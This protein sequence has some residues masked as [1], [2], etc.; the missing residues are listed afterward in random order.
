MVNLDSKSIAVIVLFIVIFCGALFDIPN[1]MLVGLC[2][3]ASGGALCVSDMFNKPKNE[4]KERERRSQETRKYSYEQNYVRTLINISNIK[5][6]DKFAATDWVWS[7]GHYYP[8]KDPAHDSYSQMIL[9]LKNKE[10]PIIE[11]FTSFVWEELEYLHSP[12]L[13]FCIVPSSQAWNETRISGMG[14]LV[15]KISKRAGSTDATACLRRIRSITPAH[16]G[17]KRNISL[18]YETIAVYN[19]ALINGGNICLFDDIRTS[20]VSMEACKQLLF[21]AGAS[22]VLGI[23]LAQTQRTC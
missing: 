9:K 21:A 7:L 6:T 1:A 20:G 13:S 22:Y 12:Y 16:R 5:N 23:V 14:M 15:N 19:P 18:H 3:L 4:L 8:S 11:A 2:V 17:G 10:L